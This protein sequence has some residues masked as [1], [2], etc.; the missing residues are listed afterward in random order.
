MK[1]F[2]WLLVV[3]VSFSSC[4]TE[5]FKDVKAKVRSGY[6][7]APSDSLKLTAS[8]FLLDNI[9]GHVSLSSESMSENQFFFDFLSSL[10]RRYERD[11]NG[12]LIIGKVK[13][14]DEEYTKGLD[15]LIIAK[16]FSHKMNPAYV[17]DSEVIDAEFLRENIEDAFYARK[18]FPWAQGV[19]FWD[20]QEY[21]LP[22]RVINTHWRGSRRFFID[23]YSGMVDSLSNAGLGLAEVAEVIRKDIHLWFK[24]DGQLNARWP[25]LTPMSFENI[26]RGRLG[27]CLEATAL[28]VSAMRAMG[29]PVAF[30]SIPQW[31][32]VNSTHYF[33]KVLDPKLDTIEKLIDNANIYR[34]TR[35]IVDGSSYVAKPKIL[36]KSYQVI[37]NKTIPKVFRKCFSRQ[38]Q[39]L[40]ALVP[41]SH[42][43]PEFFEDDR[44]KDVTKEYLETSDVSL[45]LESSDR[46]DYAYLCVFNTKGWFPVQWGQIR[47]HR[48]KFEDMGKNIVYLPAYFINN[49]L[50]PAAD[51]F[52]LKIDGKTTVLKPQID[53]TIV[54]LYRKFRFSSH[55]VMN[56]SECVGARFQGCNDV[57]LGDTINLHRITDFIH[58]KTEVKLNNDNNFRYLLFQFSGLEKATIAS[59]E[60]WGKDSTERERR[61]KGVVFGNSGKYGN[62]LAKA[63][64]FD[65]ATYFSPKEH[66][67]SYIG[68][69]LGPENRSKVTKIVFSPRNDTN[70]IIK[71][72]VYELFYWDKGWISLGRE[73][74]E[75]FKALIYS[76]PKGALYWL[77]NKT[78]GNEERIFTYVDGN[79]LF[80]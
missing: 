15:S 8:E 70:D 22:Y 1:I 49:R 54:N 61:L 14:P 55:N 80:W 78:R 30:E 3:V 34:D 29:I 33:Y 21:V 60:F 25:F 75:D 37:Y 46:E 79:Q 27:N 50:V 36:P 13:Y 18:N 74:G 38:K 51:P 12:N 67:V 59:L 5:T 56:A 6:S 42:R 77:R 35:H 48:V 73:I 40:R 9:E 63:F 68:L 43:V 44:L 72:Q 4:V 19:P 52:V 20:F 71:G 26:V 16:K 69:D 53:N 31:G 64:D 45:T 28:R 65:D 24:E 2:F 32:N 10:A 17:S 7:N 11:E 58:K 76:A 62:D 66:A 39:S 47:N 23:K 41:S 57:K